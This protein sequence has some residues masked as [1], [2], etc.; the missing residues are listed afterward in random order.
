[1]TRLRAQRN[2]RTIDKIRPIMRVK[3]LRLR[4][5]NLISA[6]LQDTLV[7]RGDR[8]GECCGPVVHRLDGLD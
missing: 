7:V 6:A 5:L 8:F 1:M 4:D 2:N 3:A